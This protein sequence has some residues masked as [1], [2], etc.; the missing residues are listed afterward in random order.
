MI[1]SGFHRRAL[2]AGTSQINNLGTQSQKLPHG[3]E[4]EMRANTKCWTKRNCFCLSTGSVY[5][6]VSP[7]SSYM[8]NYSCIL[9][10][11]SRLMMI[12]GHLG[13]M[14]TALEWCINCLAVRRGEIPKIDVYS[15]I[16]HWIYMI[17]PGDL[18]VLTILCLQTW[19]STIL[20]SRQD[21]EY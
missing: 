3:L 10:N 6:C 13:S 7:P 16:K 14:V 12:P 21:I 9:R 8:L 19:I 5:T 20:I 2:A 15:Y 17:H 1:A 11:S 18:G 4:C